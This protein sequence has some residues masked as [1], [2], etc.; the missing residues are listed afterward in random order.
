M[1]PLAPAIADFTVRDIMTEDVVTVPPEA[2]ARELCQLLDVEKVGG[3]PV[4]E[5]DG[6]VVGV[7]S[8]SDLVGAVTRELR[9]PAWI[10]TPADRDA[11][12]PGVALLRRIPETMLDGWTV[13]DIMTPATLSVSP[14]T[15]LPDL[16]RFLLRAGVH[17]ALVMDN[18]A[19]V[20]IVSTTDVLRAVSEF[21]ELEELADGGL[22]EPADE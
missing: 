3:V 8:A 13:R 15:T 14:G 22:E 1:T 17:R 11:G 6:R 9:A 16:A 12:A 21:G 7:V 4:V 18:R 20:G 19:L 10:V 5:A 2:T